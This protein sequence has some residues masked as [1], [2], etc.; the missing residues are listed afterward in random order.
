MKTKI[1]WNDL[2]EDAKKRLSSTIGILRYTNQDTV[3]ASIS[4]DV[5]A[6]V[7]VED[8]RKSVGESEFEGCIYLKSVDIPDSVTSIGSCAFEDCVSLKSISIPDS[9][10]SIGDYAFKRCES[11]ESIVI[12][13]GVT[14]IGDYLF[15]DCVSLKSVTIPNSVTSIGEHAFDG[16]ES[17]ECIVI[18]EGVTS[19]GAYAFN[20]CSSL[21]SV[22]I[23]STV[24]D[25]DYCT[26]GECTSLESVVI[27]D[28]VTVY[29][30]AFYKC[31]DAL[32]QSNERVLNSFVTQ[33]E[34]CGTTINTAMDKC[35]ELTMCGG[36][37]NHLCKKCGEDIGGRDIFDPCTFCG[38]YD[39]CSCQVEC[40]DGMHRPDYV[41]DYRWINC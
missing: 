16:C 35:I 24:V 41:D 25:I 34:S 28:G 5:V 4:S 13:E 2:T 23:P 29:H 19:I 32:I 31:N 15:A 18:P 11:L 30:N 39:C 22:I 26:F 33:C 38:G 17:L 9:V 27:P 20:K 3:I 8:G 14:V 36:G 10:T 12:P 40:E 37:Q 6:T 1:Y 7:A 21:K